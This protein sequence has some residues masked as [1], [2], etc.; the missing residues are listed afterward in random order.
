MGVLVTVLDGVAALLD[1]EIQTPPI[2]SGNTLDSPGV[3]AQK[4]QHTQRFLGCAEVT[5]EPAGISRGRAY[6]AARLVV[7][8]LDRFALAVRP[9][10]RPHLAGPRDGVALAAYTQQH[11]AGFM[12]VTSGVAAGRLLRN[13][14]LITIPGQAPKEHS[15][16]HAALAIERQL[17]AIRVRDNIAVIARAAVA[18]IFAEIGMRFKIICS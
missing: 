6:D 9:R 15:V 8:S 12:S 4:G 10:R 14:P 16:T 18:R 7:L 11:G 2:Y 17:H 1:V 3:A 13:E 5:V